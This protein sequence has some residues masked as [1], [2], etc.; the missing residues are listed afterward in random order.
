MAQSKLQ[1][2]NV[3]ERINHVHGPLIGTCLDEQE[4]VQMCCFTQHKAVSIELIHHMLGGPNMDY[5]VIELVESFE[6]FD[7]LAMNLMEKLQNDK[8]DILFFEDRKDS[9]SNAIVVVV[10]QE[11]KK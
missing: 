10:K 11:R 7:F 6:A 1:M 3:C 8:C 5:R 9:T 4:I 2:S